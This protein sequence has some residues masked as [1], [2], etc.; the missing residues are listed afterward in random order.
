ML[1]KACGEGMMPHTVAHLER[2]GVDP[3]GRPLRGIRY[4]DGVRHVDATFRAGKGRGVRRTVLSAA[5]RDAAEEVGV[6]LV[7]D[8]IRNISQDED[9]VRAGPFRA[10]YLAR[11]TDC[12]HPSAA[13]SDWRDR[14]EGPG[15]GAS[16]VT[17]TYRRGRTA[18]R[19]IGPQVVRPT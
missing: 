15:A 3:N 12:T 4:L 16:G 18:S 13:T 5:M 17:F 8:D 14:T 7:R 2:L 6:R 19:S 9:S 11:R 1:D 10:R